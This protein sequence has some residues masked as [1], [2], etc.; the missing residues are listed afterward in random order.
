M[1]LNGLGRI[2]IDFMGIW[3]KKKGYIKFLIGLDKDGLE[4]T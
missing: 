1:D 2:W 3:N 4:R